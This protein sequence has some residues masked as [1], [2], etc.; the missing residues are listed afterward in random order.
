MEPTFFNGEYLIVDELSYHLR[1][2]KRGEVIV[3]R[4]PKN[5]EQFYIKRVIGLPGERLEIRE[6][7]ITIYNDEYPQG[8]VLDESDYLDPINISPDNLVVTLNDGD[9][10][11][12]GDARRS[13]FDSRRWG[14]V[15]RKNIIGRAWLRA[16]P[17]NR[18][19]AF[20]VPSYTPLPAN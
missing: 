3:F 12:L 18:V 16:W 20:S 9:Y 6:G 19:Q 17:M 2:P 11:V 10:F 4:F 14:P 8:F 13:S 7:R 1:E 5:I 15:P